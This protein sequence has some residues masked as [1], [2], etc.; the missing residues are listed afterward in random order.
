MSQVKE[1]FNQFKSEITSVFNSKDSIIENLL[2]NNKKLE[3]S[4]FQLKNKILSFEEENN[5]GK[6]CIHCHQMFI[7]K[8]NDEVN[9]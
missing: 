5:K 9:I 1:H 7:P 3:D 2:Q 4:N 8:F 6:F